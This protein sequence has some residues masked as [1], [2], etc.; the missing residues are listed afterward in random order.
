MRAMLFWAVVGALA[1]G[2]LGSEYGQSRGVTIART[3]LTSALWVPDAV[4]QP[5]APAPPL[6]LVAGWIRLGH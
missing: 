3:A 1:A 6:P 5:P 2:V 4:P